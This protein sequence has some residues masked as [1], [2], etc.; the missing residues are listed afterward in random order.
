[1]AVNNTS[2]ETSP[3][4]L[5]ASSR[6]AHLTDYPDSHRTSI[7][8][9][10]LRLVCPCWLCHHQTG[11][12]AGIPR[13]SEQSVASQA[14]QRHRPVP[15][16]PPSLPSE[17]TCPLARCP[18]CARSPRLPCQHTGGQKM[19]CRVPEIGPDQRWEKRADH[20]GEQGHSR[21]QSP[22]ISDP[23]ARLDAAHSI[24]PGHG[25]GGRR[26]GRELKSLLPPWK[27]HM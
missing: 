12:M 6:R 13:L 15:L 14:A 9:S 27:T 22:P 23:V 20:A 7:K 19:A 5:K 3:W 8:G 17:V 1:M 16:C 11:G 24:L 4:D 26:C 2:T 10:A 18:L 21:E 25:L